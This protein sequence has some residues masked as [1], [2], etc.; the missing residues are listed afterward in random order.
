MILLIAAVVH[1]KL[2][3][4]QIVVIR[5][6]ILVLLHPNTLILGLNE[7]ILYEDSL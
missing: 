2:C 4:L 6:V 7:L 5:V 3:F 1:G